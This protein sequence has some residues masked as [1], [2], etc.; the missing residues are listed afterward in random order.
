MTKPDG[1]CFG[2]V[3]FG[4]AS[5]SYF[6]YYFPFFGHPWRPRGR[7]GFLPCIF[8][9]FSYFFKKFLLFFPILGSVTWCAV[10]F[11]NMW[12]TI[13]MIIILSLL[14]FKSWNLHTAKTNIKSV[15]HE[16]FSSGIHAQTCFESFEWQTERVS[17]SF[18]CSE[19]FY[20]AT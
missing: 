2:G 3:F 13:S 9:I 15:C 18:I 12:N 4:K 14:L 16:W 1:S 20:V 5:P 6:S 10:I 7:V 8:L 17:G 19:V 11:S